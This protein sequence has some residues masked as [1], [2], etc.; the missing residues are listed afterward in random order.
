MDSPLFHRD[1]GVATAEPAAQLRE[2]TWEKVVRPAPEAPAP[3]VEDFRAQLIPAAAL[4]PMPLLM[5]EATTVEFTPLEP[6]APPAPAPAHAPSV[7]ATLDQVLSG[8][9]V[10]LPREIFHEPVPEPLPEPVIVPVIVPATVYEVVAPTPAFSPSITPPS[11]PAVEAELNRLAFLPEIEEPLG[12]VEVPAILT[13]DQPIVAAPFMPSLSQHDMYA[14]RASVAPVAPRRNYME[15]AATMAPQSRRSK[16]HPIRRLFGTIVLLGLL[17][18][19]LF[20]AKYYF[21]DQRWSGDV[22]P[23][24]AEV[25][26]ARGLTFDHAVQVSTLPAAEYSSKLIAVTLG[27]NTS[28]E[29]STA[30]EWRALGLLSGPLDIATVGLAGLADAPA[31]YDAGAETIYVVE[32]LPA[33][34]RRFAVQRALTLALLDQEYGWSG[35]VAHSPRAVVTG[36]RALYDADALSTATALLDETERVNVLTQ[37]QALYSAYQ[38]PASSVPYA[39]AAATR[40]GLALRPYFDGAPAA[41]R[42]AV[43]KGAT[44]SDGTAMDLRRLLSGQAETTS[45][46]SQGMLFWYHVLAT[47]LDNNTAWQVALSWRD[48]D[49]SVVSGTSG[50]CVTALVKVDPLGFDNAAN[51]FSAWA[52][53]A[54]AAA[55]TAVTAAP[56]TVA[57]QI[58]VTACDPGD[59]TP[60]NDGR[61]RLS[62]GGAPLRAEQFRQ[63]MLAFPQLTPQ[64][65]ACAVYSGDP[66]S[67]ADERSL[68]DPLEG[69]GVL[70]SHPAPDPNTA[71]CAAA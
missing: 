10:A 52:A 16:R 61:V 55:R 67:P 1:P 8:A 12:P 63:L 18:G 45:A 38:I 32:G 39:T 54:P 30:G 6:V 11:T 50:V 41:T 66:V 64:Q 23:L 57:G 33:D 68:V 46:Q 60:T 70:A 21:L 35:R 13:A 17:G 59:A 28:N 47:R 34:L 49:V 65:L 19:G 2:L 53:A 58:T 15:L 29:V 24:A 71:G 27:V 36:T 14:P 42:D 3:T 37:Q 62:L 9:G 69:W 44:I 43:E 40:S 56:G 25:E 48:D 20:A 31:F 4:P 7:M 5:P 51:A 26:T 22:K